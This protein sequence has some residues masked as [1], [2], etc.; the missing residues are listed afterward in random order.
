M[1]DAFCTLAGHTVI[2]ASIF[3]PP[4][5]PWYA[6]LVLEQAPELAGLVKLRAGALE[7]VGTIDPERDGVFGLQRRCSVVAGAGAWSHDVPAKDYHNDARIKARTI[8]EDA[9]RAVGEVLGGF[10]PAAE[11]IGI[12]YARQ[13]AP[14]SRA[15]L[16]VIGGVQW[17]VDFAGVTQVGARASS[18]VDASLYELLAFDPRTGDATLAV[19]DLTAI[20]IGSVL[21]ERL[22][23]P[24]AIREYE[25]RIRPDELRVH[26][27]LGASPS[28]SGELAGLVSSIALHVQSG[29]LWGKYLY[30]VSR[31]AGDRVELQAVSARPGLPDL[32][33]LSMVPGIAG[34]HATLAQGAHAYVEFVEGDRAK[35]IV[36]GFAGKDGTG[37]VPDAL[38]LCGGGQRVARQGDLVQCG[39]TGAQIVLTGAPLPDGGVAVGVPYLVSFS[40]LAVPQAP[41]YGS[42]ST[43]SPKVTSG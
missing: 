11:R 28:G 19:D 37:F 7:L 22:E 39:G 5:G 25:I 31:M 42:I 20:G 4:V 14:A 29:R 35:P 8:A 32:L 13:V 17:W 1:T 40:S 2:E 23:T 38:E 30:R 41:L 3:V 43:G 12:D 15:L 27:R 16:D 21:S 26:A 24:K 10:L 9:A 6:D 36:T 34:A 18:P 33:P